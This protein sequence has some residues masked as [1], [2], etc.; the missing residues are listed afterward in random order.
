MAAL[1]WWTIHFRVLVDSDVPTA[2]PGDRRAPGS[3]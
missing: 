1:S 3:G 2:P